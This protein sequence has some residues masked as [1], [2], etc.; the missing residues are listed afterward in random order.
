MFDCS[1]SG[2]LSPGNTCSLPDI[3]ASNPFAVIDRTFLV[4]A[5]VL[6]LIGLFAADRWLDERKALAEDAK[7]QAEWAR[8]QRTVIRAHRD[9]GAAR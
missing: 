1:I 2:Q 9:F 4:L 5:A 6:A 8:L 3:I 7:A